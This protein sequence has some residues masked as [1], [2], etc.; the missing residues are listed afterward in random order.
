MT[1][2]KIFLFSSICDMMAGGSDAARFSLYEGITPD[3][4]ED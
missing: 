2:S 1:L 4:K 3:G